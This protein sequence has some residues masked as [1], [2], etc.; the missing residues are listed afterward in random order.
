MWIVRIALSR[1]YTFIVLALLLAILGPLTIATMATDIFPAIRIPVIGVIWTYNG[2]PPQEMSGRITAGFERASLVA[3]NDID[4]IE[5]Q[6]ITGMAVVK[7][8]FHEGANVDLSMSQVTAVAQAWLRQLPPGT[9][10]PFILSYNASSVP[11]IQLAL[12][13]QTITEQGLFD[14]AN[15]FVRT[16]LA[17]VAGASI[18]FPYGGRQRQIQI[19]LDQSRMRERHISAQDIVATINAQNLII[20]AGTE[21][22][23]EFE[24]NVRLNGSPVLAQDMNDLP[25]RIVNGTIIYLHDVAHARDGSAPQTNIVRVDGRRATLM[26]IQKTGDASTLDIISQI[27]GRLPLIRA[28]SPPALRVAPIGDQSVFVKAAISGV[29]R[30]GAIAAA[31]TGL[32]ILLFLGSWRSTIIITISIPLS[33]LCSIIALFFLGQTINIMTLGGLA[34][35]VGILVDDA[36]VAIENINAHLEA[37][38]EVEPAILAGAQ[39]I[40][41]PAFVATLCIC[42]VF[43]PMFFLGG[44]ARYLFVPLAEAICFAM[45]ASY[46]LSRTLVPTLAKYWL[47][48]HQTHAEDAPT[49]NPLRRWQQGFERGF[50]GVRD[51][52]RRTLEGTIA[53]RSVFVPLFLGFMLVSL[54]LF[55]WL[56][57]NFFPSVDSG[58]IKLHV[59]AH[60]GLRVE[61]TARL[62]DQVEDAVRTVIPPAEI[63][64]VV[65]NIGLPVSGINLTYSTSAP[66]TAADAD[67]LITLSATHRPTAEYVR[68][69]RGS[70]A[71]AF[72]GVTFAFLP[73]DIVTQILNFGAPA[74]IDVQVAGFDLTANNRY[75][76]R[77]LARIRHVPGIADPHIQQ[78]YDYPEFDVRVDR[79]RAA[80][81]GLTQRDVANDLLV[82]LTGTFQTNPTFWL[83]TK[84]G[85]SYPLVAQTPQPQ[86]D[87]LDTLRD[88]P[89]GGTGGAGNQILGAVATVLRGVGPSV[90][91][92]YNVAPTVDLYA[93]TQDRDLGA[94]ATDIRRI[95]ADMHKDLPRGS[96]ITVRGQAETMNTAFTALYAGLGFATLLVYLL[97]VVNFQSWTDAF[98]IVTGTPV[99]VP[100]LTGAIMSIGV[101]TANSILVVSFARDHMD[102]EGSDAHTAAVEAGYTRF[103]PVLMTALAMMIGMV[104]MALGL[105]EGGEQNAPLGRAVIGGLCF[106]TTAT[107][108]FVPAVFSMIHGR[109]AR[110]PAPENGA[111]S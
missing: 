60:A 7:L 4:H 19:D 2:L 111:A 67:I 55:L 76:Q 95:V 104:P 82:S 35:A 25:I 12:S 36:T 69:L 39:E 20:P 106:A 41:V 66:T 88:I 1:P 87:S 93:T 91:T 3:V 63:G 8:F 71:A 74:P 13:S 46:L 33:I 81:L 50:Q 40:A 24:Y 26:T 11:I 62:C 52:Y 5:S 32:M 83:D 28:S 94:V 49:R 73:T 89:I 14:L 72:P 110:P 58:Q 90:E 92:H 21:K 9:T 54:L 84:N 16:Q 70:L 85:V 108:V 15:N 100:A 68:R 44:V 64:S 99:S 109:G 57:S 61:E 53:R 43:T 29:V 51:R 45:F 77:L 47:K 56:G 98:I 37:G 86:L 97:I 30:E 78:A 42:I 105:G 17:G 31:L 38:E 48:P 23:G 27:K 6:S 59:R 22:V 18:P 10:P 103:R 75:A 34:L 65:D 102:R 79:S 96:R 80:E 107:L 101:A